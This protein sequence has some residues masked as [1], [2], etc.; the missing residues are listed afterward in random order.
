[1][2]SLQVEALQQSVARDGPGVVPVSS[3]EIRIAAI[4]L[5]ALAKFD[6]GEV[7]CN[8]HGNDFFLAGLK[9]EAHGDGSR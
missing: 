8:D 1:M 4:P 7:P 9:S 6:D 3:V 2:A 5:A